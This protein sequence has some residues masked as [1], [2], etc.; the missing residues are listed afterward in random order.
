[1]ALVSQRSKQPNTQTGFTITELIIGM[2]VTAIL[3]LTLVAFIVGGLQQY[4]ASSVRNSLTT[5]TQT[6]LHRI[7][8][9]IRNSAGLIDTPQV[10]DANAPTATGAWQSS[11]TQL[12]L[13]VVPRDATGKALNLV[14][15]DVTGS[16]ASIVYYIKNGALYRRVLGTG[17]PGE[18]TQTLGCSP[19]DPLGGCDSDTRI[20]NNIS[21][22]TF[23]WL[24]KAGA[25]TTNP[26]GTVAITSYLSLNRKQAG[27]DVA[28]KDSATMAPR[29]LGKFYTDAPLAVGPGGFNIENGSRIFGSRAYILG[30]LT[31]GAGSTI[32]S[33]ASPIGDLQ[34]ANYGCGTP[35]N[36]PGICAPLEP[37]HYYGN[38]SY[39]NALNSVYTTRTCA[40][41]Q[42]TTSS[43]NGSQI[44]GLVPGCVAPKLGLPPFNKA[45]FTSRMTS[46]ITQ[47]TPV[48]S[49][50]SPCTVPI[51]ANTKFQGDFVAINLATYE[52]GGDLYITGKLTTQG[53]PTFIVKEGM[54]KRPIVVV[55][56]PINTT[57]TYF[58]ANSAGVSPI[59]ISFHSADAACSTSD[60][61]SDQSME[62]IYNTLNM[63]PGFQYANEP[64]SLLTP[65]ETKGSFYAYYGRL[66]LIQF[67]YFSGTLAGQAVNMWGGSIGSQ[68]LTNDSWPTS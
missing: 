1:M 41:G 58:K 52:L 68:T 60:T 25:V 44:T 19:A 35:P 45:V 66:N 39:S 21:T 48:C 11:N 34:I 2:F 18:T 8:D 56:G 38:T 9:D 61:C 36:Y 51:S 7:N 17:Q 10:V 53:Q 42:T 3:S 15:G 16:Y 46:T 55:N 28:A 63:S 14:S 22:L 13:A 6:A 37:M 5:D 64:I 65:I 49:G 33:L 62:R 30:S 67:N 29:Q 59:F 4:S 47:T 40:T 24:D 27:Q 12:V 32:G 43:F 26:S 50:F 57:L 54:T 31:V 20:V 23:T